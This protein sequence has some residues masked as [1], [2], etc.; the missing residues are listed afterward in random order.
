MSHGEVMQELGRTQ[1]AWLQN[2][3]SLIV[4]Y[5]S[6]WRNLSFITCYYR[7]FFE[8]WHKTLFWVSVL[9][10]CKFD[11]LAVIL[12]STSLLIKYQA[13]S[14]KAFFGLPLEDFSVLVNKQILST[15]I[16][17][18]I[19]PRIWNQKVF[20]HDMVPASQRL[21][22]CTAGEGTVMYIMMGSAEVGG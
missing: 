8:P 15:S 21:S 11:E 17:P 12:Y 9:V 22:V 20:E 13:K 7:G 10:T 18:C 16:M 19:G 1:A 3:C 5:G 2:L 14:K 6:D 4:W